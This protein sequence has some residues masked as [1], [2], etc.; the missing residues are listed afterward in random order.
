MGAS[1][2]SIYPAYLHRRQVFYIMSSSPAENLPPK[3][4]SS[5]KERSQTLL[6]LFL[7]IGVGWPMFSALSTLLFAVMGLSPSSP[8][9]LYALALGGMLSLAGLFTGLQGLKRFSAWQKRFHTVSGTFSGA[10]LGLFTFGLLSEEKLGWTVFGLVLGSLALTGLAQWSGGPPRSFWRRFWR[11]TIS[12]SGTFCN[13]AVAFGFSVWA[14]AALAAGELLL[15][16]LMGAIA[17]LYLWL[18]RLS[19]SV[20]TRDLRTP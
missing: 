12:L 1:V 17:L 20:L 19:L 18:T 5:A 4:R 11:C 16:M 2:L 7:L 8:T 6:L 9:W 13:Y 3:R 14:W 10:V 15:L